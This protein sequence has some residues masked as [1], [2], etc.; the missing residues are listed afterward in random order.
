MIDLAD[1]GITEPA[2]MIGKLKVVS[3]RNDADVMPKIWGSVA[4]SVVVAVGGARG[5]E[6]RARSQE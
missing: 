5:R 6:R 2:A 1:A 3:Y 4:K